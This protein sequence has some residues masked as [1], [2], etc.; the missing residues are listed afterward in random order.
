[1]TMKHAPAPVPAHTHGSVTQERMCTGDSVS[2]CLRHSMDQISPLDLTTTQIPRRS[3]VSDGES[4]ARSRSGSPSLSVTPTPSDISGDDQSDNKHHPTTKRFLHKYQ[5]QQSESLVNDEDL[6]TYGKIRP[7]CRVISLHSHHYRNK[8]GRPTA[9]SQSSVS[10]QSSSFLSC[11]AKPFP[12][13]SGPPTPPAQPTTL[14]NFSTSPATP[15]GPGKNRPEETEEQ[16]Q[17]LSLGVPADSAAVSLQLSQAHQVA[18]Q[19]QG[20]LQDCGQ[21][22]GLQAVGAP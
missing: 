16:S 7:V 10:L 2:D 5:A 20:R 1:M 9:A 21:Q 3:S 8:S 11:R 22:G 12:W 14:Q 6:I 15:T 19:G 18:G 4:G 17:F 13:R